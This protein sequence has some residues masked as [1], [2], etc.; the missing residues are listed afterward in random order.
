MPRPAT[1]Q[2]V[3]PKGGRGW[4]LRFTA[5]GK[6]R[7]VT[8]GQTGEGWN[9]QRAEAELR[10]VLADVERGIWQ[11]HAPA[12]PEPLPQA[13]SFHEFASEWFE[14]NQSGWSERTIADYRWALSFHLLPHFKDHRL[15]EITV[16]AVDGYRAAKLREGRL[17]PAQVNKTLKRLSQILE[18]AEE[19][20]HIPRNPARGKRRRAKVTKQQ[21]SWVEPEQ[22]PSLIEGGSSYMRPVVATLIGAGLRVSEAVELDWSAVNLATGTLTVGRAKTDAGSYRAVDLPGGLVEELTEWKM[23]GAVELSKWKA[24]NPDGGSP[25]FLSAHA[26]RIRRQSAAN[27]A[28]RLKTAIKRAN[29]KLDKLGI[30]PISERVT[31]HSL[32]RAFASLRAASGDDPVYIAEQ[33]GHTD[34]R[35]TLTAYTKAVKRRVKLS[36]AYLAEYETALAWAALPTVEKAAKGSEPLSRADRQGAGLNG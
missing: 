16:E 20:G 35:F 31:P 26:G 36:G 7:F 15:T 32:R 9:R 2:V 23:R 19:Y 18:V 27:V 21:R 33:L 1:G 13:P 25:V 24:A 28:R 34:P 30:E 10:H 29:A 11:P 6:R 14:A 8:L 17:A 4:A 3:P 12:Q 5:Y 22:V